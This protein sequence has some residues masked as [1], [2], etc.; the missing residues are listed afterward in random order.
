MQEQY[1]ESPKT[2]GQK[3]DCQKNFPPGKSGL[4]ENG[5]QENILHDL[6]SD[7]DGILEHTTEGIWLVDVNGDI[8]YMNPQMAEIL[9]VKKEKTTGR[10]LWDYIAYDDTPSLKAQTENVQ[11]TGTAE[12]TDLWYIGADGTPEYCILHLK[13]VFN[14]NNQISGVVGRNSKASGTLKEAKENLE[15]YKKNEALFRVAS[16][17]MKLGVFEWDAKS[18]AISL[19]NS[20]MNEILGLNPEK[21]FFTWEELYTHIIVPEDLADFKSSL[22]AAMGPDKL[23]HFLCRIKRLDNGEKRW[24]AFSGI[25]NLAEDGTPERLTG[26]I[27]DITQRKQVEEERIQLNENLE[28]QVNQKTAEITFQAQRL[29]AL[30]NKLSRT[31]HKERK[32][33][34]KYLHDTIQPLIVSARMHLW[35]V[36]RQNSGRLESEEIMDKLEHILEESLV[37]LR[38]VTSDLSPPIHSGSGLAGALNWLSKKMQTDYDMTVK[39]YADR[40]P[41]PETEESANLVFDCVKELLFN[42]VKHAGTT[43]A[44]VAISGDP[45]KMMKIVVSDQ[46]NGFNKEMIEKQSPDEMTFGL[47]NVQERLAYIGGEMLVETASGNGTKITLSVPA[48]EKKTGSQ[49]SGPMKTQVENQNDKTFQ[50]TGKGSLIDILIVDDHKVLRDGLKGML[51]LEPDIQVVGEAADGRRAIEQAEKLHPDL[52][53]MDVNLGDEMEGVTA[54][55]KILA[56]M[57][58]VKVIA[59]SMYDDEGI[60]RTMKDAG[61]SAY[62]SKTEPSENLIETI[63]NCF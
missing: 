61:A 25:F 37:S 41:E 58:R 3:A 19:E 34:A 18:D 14:K 24:A 40:C 1:S 30:A 13:P 7:V 31:E 51:Q 9:R 54:T 26:V 45:G 32:R 20:R 46:G 33:L 10:R 17:A 8:A 4:A 60:A 63:R 48:A 57:P 27:S 42:V 62:I 52:V 23:F 36:K 21:K 59:L 2:G 53:I 12:Q 55:R 44:E 6:K 5:V 56:R 47:F 15:F 38:S 28:D 39:L 22:E 29:R 16:S 50:V 35:E 11:T 49:N 43:E